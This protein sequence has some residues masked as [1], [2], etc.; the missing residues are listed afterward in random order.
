MAALI[1]ETVYNV[2]PNLNGK[3]MKFEA[4]TTASGDWCVFPD[5][6]GVIMASEVDGSIAVTAYATGAVDLPA[7]SW[8]ATDVTL[9]YDSATA[10]QV[11]TSGYIMVGNEIIYYEAGGASAESDLTGCS[12]GCFGTTAA[13]HSDGVA[14]YFINT[15]VFTLDTAGPIRGFADVIEE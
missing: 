2:S 6:I 10:T 12:R 8:A 11:P 5:P 1:T 4:P 9:H 15:V 7:S 14:V 3:I 13:A